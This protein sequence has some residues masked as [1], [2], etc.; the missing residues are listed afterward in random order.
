MLFSVLISVYKSDDAG[1]FDEALSSIFTQSKYIDQVV[2][3]CD[4][5][6][7]EELEDVI[8]RYLQQAQSTGIEFV[9]PRLSKNQGLGRALQ[10]GTKFCEGKYVV[11]MDSD[12][13]SLNTRMKELAAAVSKYPDID[14][15]GAQIEEF[16]EL[17]GDLRLKR[18][19]P[20]DS[21]EVFKYSKLRNPINH[22]TAC[23]KKESL[24]KV[25]GY[26]DMLWHEDYYLWIRM[27]KAH[28]KLINLKATHVYVR[29][30]D[31]GERRSGLKYL[32]AEVDFLKAG[33]SIGHFSRLDAFKYIIIRMTVRLIPSGFASFIYKHLRK[34]I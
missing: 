33:L 16:I 26:E 24:L 14:V 18:E 28:C 9:N 19:V 21:L 27:L 8:S 4:G 1:H 12:D 32:M 23:I 2:L 34:A 17:P 3:V 6:I 5:E 30:K 25:C 20:L 10:Y 13:I 31:F 29:V 15:I 22:V 7:T 11:R